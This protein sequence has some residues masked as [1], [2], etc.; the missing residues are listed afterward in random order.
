MRSRRSGV[1]ARRP[2]PCAATA[3]LCASAW[4]AKATNQRLVGARGRGPVRLALR[5]DLLFRLELGLALRLLGLAALVPLHPV[6]GP[7][8]HGC[9]S[10]LWI[11]ALAVAPVD[12]EALGLR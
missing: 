4:S 1:P 8:G 6:V 11:V 3:R 12:Q 7:S 2:R 9:S 5:G 10:S